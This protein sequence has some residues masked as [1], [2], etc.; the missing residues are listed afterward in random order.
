MD[1]LWGMMVDSFESITSLCEIII[2]ILIHLMYLKTCIDINACLFSEYDKYIECMKEKYNYKFKKVTE[3]ILEQY[4]IKYKEKIETT[5]FIEK[6]L[7][8]LSKKKDI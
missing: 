2:N 5:D 7:I 8:M 4:H 3:D 1:E 6:I